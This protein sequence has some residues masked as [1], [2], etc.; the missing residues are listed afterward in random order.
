MKIN[1]FYVAPDNRSDDGLIEKLNPAA[2]R[3]LNCAVHDSG[4]NILLS[5]TWNLI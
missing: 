4:F 5:T 2:W 1:K 3:F